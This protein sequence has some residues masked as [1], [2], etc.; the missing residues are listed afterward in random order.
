MTVIKRQKIY[1]K[2]WFAIGVIGLLS[3][4]IY[5]SSLNCPFIFDARSKIIKNPDIKCLS[6]IKTKLIYPYGKYKFNRNDPSR[7]LTYLTFTLN[8]YFGRLNTFGYHLF[9]LVF[10]IF[11]SIL[12]FFLT[13][14]II[15]Y[16]YRR[17][18]IFF[19]FIVAIFFTVHPINTGVVLYVVNR[20]DILATFFYMSSVLLFAK[21]FEGNR[22]LYFFS[23]LCFI[24]SLSSKQIAVTL[25]A[26][27]LIFDY[28]FLSNFAVSK[29][30]EKKLYHVSFWII[31]IIYLLFR[32]F[33]LGGIG[34]LEA[35]STLPSGSYF[36]TQFYVMLKYLK[37][38]LIPAGLSVNHLIKSVTTIFDPRFLIP[39]FLIIGVFIL[40]WRFYRGKNSTSK[41]FLFA[42]LWFFIVLS[43]TS[44]FLPTASIM[45]E[46]RLYLSGFGFYLAIVLVYFLIFRSNTIAKVKKFY[47]KTNWILAG[48]LSV[49]I[50][51]L[52]LTAFKRTQL[53]RTPFLLW[54]DVIF[55]YPDS[56]RAHL[57]LGLSYHNQKEYKKASQEYQKAIELDTTCASAHNYLG[58]LYYDWK[59]Y[60]EAF[61]EY[62]KAL[63]LFPDY[64][65][66]HSNLGIYYIREKQYGKAITAF[67]L[68][69]QIDPEHVAALNNIGVIYKRQGKY[70][71]ALRYFSRSIEIEPDN[72][73]ACV[74]IGNIYVVKGWIDKAIVEYRRALE[75]EPYFTEAQENLDYILSDKG[76]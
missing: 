52:G 39:F 31:L 70:T 27:V 47:N 76:R 38:L 35:K 73:Y 30:I 60:K 50:F 43:P 2:N 10:H 59:K 48:L 13:K 55:R 71:E 58:L 75:I 12:V 46:N 61:Q 40:S 1:E 18:L 5:Y 57:N 69:L 66:V 7:P 64:T 22:I 23:L 6:N 49:H 41:I 29:V 65:D 20:S 53:Y 26:I 45:A 11:N 17:N 32:Y 63:E 28:I 14:T 16:T 42:I 36:F 33:Y 4:I 74:N 68:A 15:S 37:L 24:L 67:K 19:P 54:K 8:Y 25:P 72:I 34:D 56:V 21:T 3:I 9:N 62:Q 51:S 44:S